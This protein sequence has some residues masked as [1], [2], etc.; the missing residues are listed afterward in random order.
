MKIRYRVAAVLTGMMAGAGMIAVHTAPAHALTG[1]WTN[2]SGDAINKTLPYVGSTP[3]TVQNSGVLCVLGAVRKTGTTTV[4]PAEVYLVQKGRTISSG[5]TLYRTADTIAPWNES[6]TSPLFTK[7]CW[8]NLTPGMT[9][10]FGY[11]AGLG[12]TIG[13]YD[14][15]SVRYANPTR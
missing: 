8:Q 9:V 10:N 12:N 11:T 3:I 4:V 5:K 1:S 2:T 6:R 14:V 13:K 15:V 7:F